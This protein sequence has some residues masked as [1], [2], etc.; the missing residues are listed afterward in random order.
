M[1][2]VVNG[3]DHRHRER[4]YNADADGNVHVG[5]ACPQRAV[6]GSE[7]WLSRIGRR[8]QRNQ[9][10]QPVEEIALL[11]DHVGHISGPYG[12]RHHHHVH[13]GKGGDAEA[14]QQKTR[15]LRLQRFGANRLER[16]GLVTK[17]RQPVDKT[18]RVERA[19]LPFQ[20]HPTIGQINPRQRHVRKPGKAALD[21]GHAAGATNAL[22]RQIDM[23]QSRTEVPDIV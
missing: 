7:K 17:L 1:F 9:G 18:R 21:L 6:G 14:A 15:L 11:R 16:I 4:Q 12:D 13:R 19:L 5:A 3:F 8:R 10:G 2:G 23:R 20:R 22:D